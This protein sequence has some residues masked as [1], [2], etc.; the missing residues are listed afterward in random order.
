MAGFV[1][2]QLADWGCWDAVPDYAAI[3]KSDAAIDPASEFA[4]RN[5]LKRAA[6]AGVAGR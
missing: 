6:E 3:V 5:Y 2:P 1:A 4:I